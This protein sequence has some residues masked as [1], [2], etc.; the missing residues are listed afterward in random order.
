MANRAIF[1]P[2]GTILG[3]N[4]SVSNVTTVVDYVN[5]YINTAPMAKSIEISPTKSFVEEL[6]I[7]RKSLR[8]CLDAYV[9]RLEH[10]L[11]Q[12]KERALAHGTPEPAAT[13]IRDLR[14][15][16]SL[17]RTLEIKPDKGR[18]KDLK[19]IDSLIEELSVIVANWSK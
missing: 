13:H 6:E 4:R 15:M 17:C 2:R 11:D 7:L 19:K 16:I 3:C 12:I 5:L 1:V 14:D 8:D 18:R 10:E 9:Q